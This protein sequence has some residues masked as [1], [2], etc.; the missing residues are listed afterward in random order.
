MTSTRILGFVGV[1]LCFLFVSLFFS[2]PFDA[3]ATFPFATNPLWD[4]SMQP[5]KSSLTTR[6]Q[7]FNLSFQT[8]LGEEAFPTGN[9]FA[10]IGS[11]EYWV[12]TYLTESK[13]VSAL[14]FVHDVNWIGRLVYFFRFSH[15]RQCIEHE[16]PVSS[17]VP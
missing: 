6:L 4:D 15:I 10:R 2:S 8:G 5:A 16:S 11:D 1:L 17:S 3:S 7:N 14:A 13:E 9:A 12:V